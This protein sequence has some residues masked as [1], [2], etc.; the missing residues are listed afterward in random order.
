MRRL[1]AQTIVALL[2]IGGVASAQEPPLQSFTSAEG[3]FTVMLPG[4]PTQDTATDS[5]GT[6]HRFYVLVAGGSVVSIMS[7]KDIANAAGRAPQALLASER[8]GVVNARS[9]RT[10]TSDA[11][12]NLNGV[13]G[14]AFTVINKGGINR[15][16]HVYLAGTRLY[17]LQVLFINNRPAAHAEQ[18]FNSLRIH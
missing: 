8:D 14:R 10:L 17:E 6:T 12:I 2:L 1:W 4:T 13:P 5:S 18:F 9:G 15:T 3:R 7:Y 11:E 16:V